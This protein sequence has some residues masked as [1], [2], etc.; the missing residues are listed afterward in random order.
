LR[1]GDLMPVYIRLDFNA[2]LSPVAQ[3]NA[4]LAANLDEHGVEG[5][6]P[7]PGETLWAYFHDK[8][9]EF[10]SRR[11]R[12]VTP[13]LVFDQFEE[14]F[15]LGR[16]AASLDE[17]LDELAALVENRPP[18]RLRDA[19]ETDPEMALGF[20]FA[21]EG[22]KVVLALREDFLP[23][24]EGLRRLMPSIMHNRMRLARMDGM[25]ARDVVLRSGGHLVAPG[26][27]ERIIEFVA[28][29][30]R[31]SADE[32]PGEPDLGRFEIEPALLSI[33]CRELNGQ[34]MRAGRPQITADQL[35]GAQSEI[36]AEF[37]KSSLTGLD[38]AVQ[39]FIED[40]LLTADGYRDSRP[41]AEALN[42]PGIDRRAIDRL[43]AG[44]L[45][46][47]EE[48]FGTQWVELTHDLLTEVIRQRRDQRREAQEAAAQRER[49]ERAEA[50]AATQ[51]A[52][53][54]DARRIVRRTRIALVAT[55]AML[56]VAIG[57]LAY[58]GYE[59]RLAD[60]RAEEAAAQRQLA[61]SRAT[62]AAE[63]RQLAETRAAEAAQQRQLAEQRAEEAG[64]NYALALESA[65]R[66]VNLVAE[67]LSTGEIT[68]ALAKSLLDTARATFGGLPEEREDAKTVES[69]YWLFANL[70][71]T[72]SVLGELADA[73][74]AARTEQSLA[75]RFPEGDERDSHIA[76][77][78]T[79][80][81]QALYNQGDLPGALSEFRTDRDIM[82][83]LA[84]KDPSNV[85]WQRE[86]LVSLNWIGNVLID[87][88]DLSGALA[89]YR[90]DLGITQNLA[91]KEPTNT[92]WQRNLS[93]AQEKIGNVLHAQGDLDGALAAFRDGLAIIRRLLQKE[94]GNTLWQKDATDF[95]VQIGDVLQGQGN[96]AGALAQY[97]AAL[98]ITQ[99]LVAR[100]PDNAER[101]IALAVEYG[102]LGSMLI[103]TDDPAGAL[104]AFE[105]TEAVVSGLKAHN[106]GSNTAPS[107]AWVSDRLEE[108]RKITAAPNALEIVRRLAGE[109]PAT[110]EQQRDVA[111][112]FAQIAYDK[113]SAGDAAGGVAVGE[114]RVAFARQ[115]YA[116]TPTDQ[117]KTALARALGEISWHLLLD[118]RAQEALDR[119]DEA[120]SL[121]PSLL[122]VQ[123][124]RADVLLVLG[125]FDEAKAIYV[126]DKD[127]KYSSGKTFAQVAREDFA[128]MR[129][130]DI[131]TPDMKRIEQLLA[132]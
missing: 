24:F 112:M 62:E 80:I 44:R 68:T 50:E 3:I 64:K 90:A 120:L 61:E 102:R 16:D 91:A 45:L 33:V 99:R 18:P 113:L 15:T 92:E 100:D 101:Q 73:L 66:N 79:R 53:A 126:A 89:S 31:P 41:L 63:Q 30:R 46:R 25:Q 13:V 108:A 84:D 17:F 49:A 27:A 128:E 59:S 69:R 26:V 110:P 129:K 5:P 52:A 125:R 72:Y 11:N 77:A 34:R 38:P 65:T 54:R 111:L 28:A 106:V 117:A 115:V 124:N 22:C 2:S 12:L 122:F 1:A 57:A 95:D 75:E 87:Q 40:R 47:I 97:R 67:H 96:F 6:P 78:H 42:V 20:D 43:V 93:I 105:H 76:Y 83:R 74:D 51:T 132:N 14:I 71:D 32:A 23:E 7:K 29:S 19:L 116:A 88:N 60:Q 123:G 81:G 21:A 119:A 4:A 85:D 127:K 82:Q 58:A 55:A 8:A 109:M 107:A 104:A 114:E 131:D 37:Y 118:R 103:K 9:T 56:L 36:V 35:A 130:F 48:R 70:A 121:E 39:L 98:D 86:L 94:A 10:W